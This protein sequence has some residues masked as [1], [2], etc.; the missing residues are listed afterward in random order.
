MT[1]K[2]NVWYVERKVFASRGGFALRIT[3]NTAAHGRKRRIQRRL[4]ST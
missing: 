3:A 1:L 4:I 2:K